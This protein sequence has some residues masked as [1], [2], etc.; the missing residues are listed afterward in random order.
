MKREYVRDWMTPEP[1]TVTPDTSVSRAYYL[2][3]KH[4]IRRLPVTEG[5]WLV[6]V[7][8]TRDLWAAIAPLE[9]RCSIFEMASR[10]ERLTVMHV[11]THEVVTVTADAS[12]KA[13][14]ELMLKHKVGG[15]PVMVAGRL[16]GI[17]SE[18][19]IFRLVARY[20]FVNGNYD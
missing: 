3:K 5:E 8:T 1:V 14:C 12:I 17:L 18:S 7:V 16:V 15:L 20:E 19:D 4:R 9:A 13:A 10:M 2:M 6:G 11:M